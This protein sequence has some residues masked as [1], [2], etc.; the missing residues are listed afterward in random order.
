MRSAMRR[1][2]RHRDADD[3]RPRMADRI[4]HLLLRD[5]QQLMLM[6]GLQARRDAASFEAAG[7]PARD[8]GALGKLPQRQL[9][10]RT[11]CL[12]EPQCHDRAPRLRQALAGEIA[13]ASQREREARVLLL[14]GGE[15]LDRAELHQNAREG[16]RQPVMDL[17]ADAGA[18]AQNRRLLR[19]IGEAC[20]LHRERRLLRQRDQQL[21]ALHVAG[22]AAEAQDQEADVAGAEYE[23]IDHRADVALLPVEGEHARPEL[24]RLLLDIEIH[25]LGRL[26]EAV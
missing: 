11:T 22:A 2:V 21:A 20:E 16:L 25:G 10:P 6:L 17:L 23:W 19:L 5:T 18:L 9:Q 12:I 14:A 4:A 15:F 24:L 8:G 26:A 13:N 7:H 3:I 1:L